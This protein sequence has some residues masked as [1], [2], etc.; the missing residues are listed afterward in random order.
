M[1]KRFLQT[2]LTKPNHYLLVWCYVFSRLNEEN[3]SVIYI[4][5]IMPRFDLPKSTV[6]RIIKYGVEVYPFKIET[7]WVSNN[8]HIDIQESVNKVV[9]QKK[10][11][12]KTTYT[13][14]KLPTTLYTKMIDDYDAFCQNLTGV[15][16][17]IDGAQGKSM[18][19]IIA[20]LETQCRKKRNDLTPEQLEENVLISWKYILTNWDKLDDYNRGRVKLTEINS[21]MLNILIKLKEK[22][23][24][25]KQNQR[26][27]QINQA[28]TGATT[29]DY[30]RLGS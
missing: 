12:K 27:E 22:P 28:I 4:H 25:K 7:K 24:N 8:L 10:T 11:K 18:K 15:G 5:E 1:D 14:K 21:N 13:P 19:Q 29:T 6:K 2:L 9:K 20:F 30:S 26:N 16:C 17:K 23:I 3:K